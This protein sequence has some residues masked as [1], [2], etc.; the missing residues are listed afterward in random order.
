MFGQMSK[1]SESIKG[2]FDGLAEALNENLLTVLEEL[3]EI[4][5]QTNGIIEDKSKKSNN[6]FSS[7]STYSEN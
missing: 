5:E 4:L 7:N 2:N 1:L 6:T 3:K